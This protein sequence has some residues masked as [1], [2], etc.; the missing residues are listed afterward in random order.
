MFYDYL[1][2]PQILAHAQPGAELVCLGRHGQGRILP[3][4]E[5]NARMVELARAGR[6]VVRLKGGDPAVFAHAA[7]ETAALEQR[8]TSLTRSCPASPPRWPWAAMPAFR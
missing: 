4:D 5:V 2:N 7:E 3:V 6:N 8:R 1:V